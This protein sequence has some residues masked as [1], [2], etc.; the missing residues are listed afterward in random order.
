MR[1]VVP[2]YYSDFKCI[3]DKC[4]HTCCKGWEID[5]DPESYEY[6]MKLEGPMGE[7]IRSNIDVNEETASFRLVGSEERCPFLDSN[8]LCDMILTLG[9]DSICG[10][11]TDHPRFRNFRSDRIEIGLGLACEEACRIVLGSKEPFALVDDFACSE[12][13]D[14]DERYMYETRDEDIAMI[15]N[16]E[17]P[18][19]KRLPDDVTLLSVADRAKAF[20]SLEILNPS[21]KSFLDSLAESYVSTSIPDEVSY[22]NFIAYLLF[23]H[24]E[25]NII[26]AME[27]AQLIAELCE[28]TKL[29]LEELVRMFS[30]EVEYS[31][32]NM[33]TL[34]DSLDAWR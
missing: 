3:A 7:R 31:D 11:C 13:V 22:E 24:P 2:N 19:P 30:S 6:Y 25:A 21:W 4:Q 28:I 26:F 17:L 27:S 12:D 20:A 9:E 1:Q 15:T 5:I 33:E 10:I 18:L 8:N 14:E 23:R 16:R 32:I 29:P 34:L